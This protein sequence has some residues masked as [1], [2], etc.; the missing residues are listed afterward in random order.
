MPKTITLTKPL[1]THDG[2]RTT[3]VLRDPTAG[4]FAALNRLPF[5]IERKGEGDAATSKLTLD[6]KFGLKWLAALTGVD[7]ILL[8]K[9]NKSDFMT[10]LGDLNAFLIEEGAVQPGN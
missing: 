8:S 7:E 10:A 5:E 6:F 4:D 3:L 2:E 9:M 1:T